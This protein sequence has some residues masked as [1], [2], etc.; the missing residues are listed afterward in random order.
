MYN[1]NSVLRNTDNE[2][3]CASIAHADHSNISMTGEIIDKV[4]MDGKL[5][6]TIVGHNIIVNS[7]TK[8]VMALCKGE[9]GYAGIKFWAVGSGLATWDSTSVEPLVGET[10]LTAEIGRVAI[11]ANEIKF[12]TADYAESNVPTNILQIQHIFGTNDCN[13]SW[14]EFGIFGGDATATANS[15][16][17]INKKHHP[18]ITKTS[19]MTIERTMRFTINLV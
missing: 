4:Y 9:T 2:V 14:R 18:V 15:G 5:I 1:D 17:M 19:D 13:G 7:F 16:I 8:L 10:Q 6:D 11:A 12:L 3:I